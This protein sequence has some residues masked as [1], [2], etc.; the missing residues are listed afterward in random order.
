MVDILAFAPHPD[1]VELHCSGTLVKL[2][3]E[4]YSIGIIDLTRGELSSR[5]TVE[6]RAKEIELASKIL[7]IDVREN[8]AL[9]DGGIQNDSESRLKIISILRK[10]RPRT[11]F[12][13]YHTDRHPDHENGSKLVRDAVFNS[14]LIKIKLAPPFDMLEPYCPKKNFYY[15]I[16]HTFEP[17]FIIDI[18]ETFKT[19]LEAIA[20][21]STQ[22]NSL[23]PQDGPQT[24]ISSQDFMQFIIARAQ[25]LGFSIGAKYGEGFQSIQNLEM[26][27]QG[28]M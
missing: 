27:I 28:L 26:P 23:N 14:G 6:T 16:S 8:I 5:G 4:G 3:Q 20:A 15:M 22:F 19:R 10:Y 25:Q 24:Y 13:P 21:Y 12:I 2:K 9:P 17:T 11:I 1:D 18:S 7:N